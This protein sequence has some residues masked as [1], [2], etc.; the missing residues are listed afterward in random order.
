MKW[1]KKTNIE[2]FVINV[3]VSFFGSKNLFVDADAIKCLVPCSVIVDGNNKWGSKI[4]AGWIETG[5]DLLNL[6]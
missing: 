2:E 6:Q 5:F 4:C 3:E 1:A